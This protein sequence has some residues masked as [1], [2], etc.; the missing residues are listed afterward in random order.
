MLRSFLLVSLIGL[1]SVNVAQARDAI[2][3]GVSPFSPFSLNTPIIEETLTQIRKTLSPQKVEV[4]HSDSMPIFNAGVKAGCCDFILSSSG[5]Y[6]RMIQIEVGATDI[7]TVFSTLA[8]DPNR[9]EGSVFIT[10]SSRTDINDIS[11]LKNKVIAANDTNSFSGFHIAM[12]A[13]AQ[14]GYD[15]EHFFQRIHEVGVDTRNVLRELQLGLA[16]VGVLRTCA[17]E[18]VEGGLVEFKVVAPQHVA[19]FN[20]QTSTKLY[21]NWTFSSLPSAPTDVTRK[22]AQALFSMPAQVNGLQWGVASDFTEVDRL[23][24]DLKIGP[25]RYLRTWTWERIVKDHQQ[26]LWITVLLILALIAHTLRAAYLIKKSTLKIKLANEKERAIQEESQRVTAQIERMQRNWVVDQIGTIYAHELKQ[27]LA[28]ISAYSYG[29]IKWLDRQGDAQSGFLSD[30]LTKIHQ[31][32]RMAGETMERLHTYIRGNSE[33]IPIDLQQDLQ[34]VLGHLVRSLRSSTRVKTTFPEVK[35]IVFM[36]KVEFDL[37]F[38]NLLKNAL[39]ASQH[40]STPEIHI[41]VT[42]ANPQLVEV[43]I[44]D[45]GGELPPEALENI[46]STWSRSSKAVGMGFGLPIVKSIVEKNAGRIQFQNAKGMGLRVTVVLPLYPEE[47]DL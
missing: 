23:F 17:L 6:R 31:A 37:L 15:P 32:S 45:N 19:N 44:V 12:G 18:Q 43:S 1:L 40:A 22:V 41:Q 38:H 42:R 47:K 30:K 11:D 27:P 9:A 26:A 10:L 5:F 16:D 25:Y 7:A 21:P 39:E 14:A 36:E 35:P 20:C 34:V 33:P 29:L 24:R 13:I 8:P 28:S 3:I 46:Q 2:V 4:F